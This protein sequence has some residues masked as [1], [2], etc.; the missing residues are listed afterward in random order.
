M[1]YT[2]DARPQNEG[3]PEQRPEQQASTLDQPRYLPLPR[4]TTNQAPEKSFVATWLFAW[5]LGFLGADRFYLGKVGTAVLK[6]VTFAGF[7]VWWLVD[8]ILVLAGAQRDKRGNRL[9]GFDAHR[10]AAWI[11]TGAVLAL[12]LILAGVAAGGSAANRPAASSSDTNSGTSTDATNTE[13]SAGGLPQDA[14]SPETEPEQPSAQAWADEQFG[15][16]AP[17]T[18]S[19]TG[20]N[21]ITLPKGATAGIVTATHDGSSNFVINVLDAANQSTADLLVNTIGA[22]TGATAYG[23]TALGDG[24]SLQITADGNW[25]I[26]LSPISAAPALVGAGSGDAVFLYTGPAEPLTVAHSGESNFVVTEDTGASFSFGLLINE[27]GAYTGT[28]PMSA[29][30][31]IVTVRADGAWTLQAG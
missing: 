20:D 14:A 2:D 1:T 29:G 9:A 19:G 18:Q 23:L 16:F 6:L 7:G 3:T 22:Y 13:D 17:L 10:K 11:V 27:I 8:L 24:V 28:V 30:P 21:I 12:S 4:D 26:T 25:T 15:N 5:L 31:S